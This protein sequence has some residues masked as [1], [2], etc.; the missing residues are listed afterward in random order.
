MYKIIDTGV[1]AGLSIYFNKGL[2]V[3]GRLNY[4]LSD[5]TKS[6]ADV[7]LVKLD[8]D[9]KFISLDNKDRNFNIQAS[10]GFS[11]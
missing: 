4:G 9:N 2:Y 6:K 11:F 8:A 5:I 1:L 10:I 3:T 7:S